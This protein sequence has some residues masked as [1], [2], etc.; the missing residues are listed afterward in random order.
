M[1]VVTG[2]TG[3]TGGAAAKALLAAGQKIRVVGRDAEKLE[4]FVN[5]APSFS[6]ATSKTPPS[7]T[8]AFQG[9]DAVYL[10]VPED[11]SLRRFARPS[12]TK[13]SDSFRRGRRSGESALC[14]RPQQHRRAATRRHR[15]HRRPAQPGTK[16]KS[17]FRPQRP[18]LARRLFHG[19]SDHQYSA[20]LRSMHM[21]PGGMKGDVPCPGSPPK[22]SEPTPPKRLAARNFSGSSIQE[23][24]GERDISMK[25]AAT[26][27]GERHRQTETQLHASPIHDAGTRARPNRPAQTHRRAA[28]RNVERRQRRPHRPTRAAHRREHHPDQL[29]SFV[30]ETFVPAYQKAGG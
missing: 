22:I 9:A 15:T 5:K 8:K 13:T 29:E 26:V 10:V 23:L 12:G 6:L 2:A 27:V 30:T 21:L 28:N 7:M 3:R 25:Q 4:P 16:I 20:P 19:K 11:S 18:S 1:I 17:R 24:H 14:R